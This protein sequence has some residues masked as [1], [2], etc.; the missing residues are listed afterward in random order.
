MAKIIFVSGIHGV[1]K[2]TLCNELSK[3][4]G[5]PHFSCSELIKQNSTYVER[6]KLVNNINKNQEAL[7]YGISQIKD[8]IILLDGHFCLLDNQKNIMKLDMEIFKSFN[9]ITVLNVTCNENIILKR[10]YERDRVVFPYEILLEMQNKER[11]QAKVFCRM[12]NCKLLTY[13]SPNPTSKLIQEL[14]PFN[15]G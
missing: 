14:L 10:L 11:T 5:W 15:F 7:L 2:S 4:F 8:E 1:G 6:S 12:N 13:N 3:L 9:P